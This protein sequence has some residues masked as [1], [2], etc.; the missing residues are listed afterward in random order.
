MEGFGFCFSSRIMSASLTGVFFK[1]CLLSAQTTKKRAQRNR[2]R[3]SA[4]PRRRAPAKSPAAAASG[5]GRGRPPESEGP[6]APGAPGR[7]APQAKKLGP[8][9]AGCFRA[10]QLAFKIWTAKRLPLIGEA[11]GFPPGL[12]KHGERARKATQ[13]TSAP[14][15]ARPSRGGRPAGR[16]GDRRQGV[17]QPR[18]RLGWCCLRSFCPLFSLSLSLSLPLSLSPSLLSLSP[19]LSLSL[20]LSLSPLW[21]F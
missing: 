11:P 1:R 3:E 6:R 8:W 10:R 2:E 7:A 9:A 15:E 21:G 17:F 5:A 19:P 14:A 16:G 13:Q 12:S 20:P 18:A 4:P